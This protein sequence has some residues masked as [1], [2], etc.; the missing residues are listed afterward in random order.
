MGG[1]HLPSTRTVSADEAR[2]PSA[3][4]CRGL[5]FD[6]LPRGIGT[7]GGGADGGGFLTGDSLSLHLDG[8][9]SLSLQVEEGEFTATGTGSGRRNS[10]CWCPESRS[11]T[12]TVP[13]FGGGAPAAA[14]VAAGAGVGPGTATAP[15]PRWLRQAGGGFGTAVFCESAASCRPSAES[16]STRRIAAVGMPD[17]GGGAGVPVLPPGPVLGF[18]SVRDC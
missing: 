12:K 5:A 3:D 8:D 1:C 2:L 14:G 7:S 10:V 17:P 9:G 11:K 18:L 4:D 16:P 6:A 13:D 15:N